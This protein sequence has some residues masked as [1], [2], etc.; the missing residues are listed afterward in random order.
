MSSVTTAEQLAQSAQDVNVLSEQQLHAAWSE[1]GTRTASL[2]DFSQL[3]VRKNLLTN[4]QLDRLM[5]GQRNGFFYGNYKVLY[6]VGSGTFARVFRAVDQNTDKVY[7]V[8]VLRATLSVDPR[9][10]ELF[11]REGELGAALKHPNIVPIHEVYSRGIVHYIVMDF[12]EGRNL[13]ELYKVRK[14]FAPVEAAKIMTGVAA[15][16]N[17][18]F[19]QG[20]THRDL[21]MSNV[22][23]SSAG[24][25]M[26]VDF[27]LM[28]L[29][30]ETSKGEA[31]NPRAIDYA[32]LERATGM[33][34][35]DT[36]SDIFFVGCMLYQ[37]VTGRPPL[38][39]TRDRMQRLA[40][41]RY[42]NIKPL[43]QFVPNCPPAI[44]MVI[45]KAIEFDPSRRYQT[46]GELLADLKL[47]IK[48]AESGGGAARDEH[49]ADAEG[50]GPDGE[51]RKLMIVESSIKRQDILRDL[52]KRNGYRVLVTGDAERA[53]RAF[54]QRPGR[55][56]G[57]AVLQRRN[58][59]RR[60]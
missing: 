28:A 23:V 40:K 19:Q 13:R 29:E 2:Q 43:T 55:R 42:Q 17:Y 48:R 24:V 51:Q 30:D 54:P 11:R 15:G 22:L 14:Q 16:L 53:L 3:L 25:A 12:I 6:C 39:E 10:A 27:G 7:A 26:L 37:M 45:N 50:I 49:S 36:R 56:R 8:K 33:R 57:R 21:K 4:Y 47:A 31:A 38:A 41:T 35:D 58:R 1:L 20:V 9:E 46:P 34:K 52:F 32:G 59:P 44:T 18:A 5:R 60:R